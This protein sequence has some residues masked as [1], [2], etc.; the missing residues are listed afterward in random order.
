MCSLVTYARRGWGGRRGVEN[1]VIF[2]QIHGSRLRPSNGTRRG[3]RS[4]RYFDAI[5]ERISA[6]AA[7]PFETD[8]RAVCERYAFS[9]AWRAAATVTRHYGRRV[10]TGRDDTRGGFRSRFGSGYRRRHFTRKPARIRAHV[11]VLPH[12]DTLLPDDGK[13]FL[14]NPKKKDG[15]LNGSN[16]EL[17]NV[18]TRH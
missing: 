14:L 4:L 13:V 1:R 8:A 12:F 6:A 3:R 2:H 10:F 15:R 11:Q 5:S 18:F 17:R 9:T 7:V 16:V